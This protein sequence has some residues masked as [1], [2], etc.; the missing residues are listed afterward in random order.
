MATE[1]WGTHASAPPTTLDLQMLT[2]YAKLLMVSGN[3]NSGLHACVVG[4]LRTQW[5]FLLWYD[6]VAEFEAL[7]VY[8]RGKLSILVLAFLFFLDRKAIRTFQ[9]YQKHRGNPKM[10]NSLTFLHH[11]CIWPSQKD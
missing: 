11:P 1:L 2:D 4:A 10:M 7:P 5:S 9:G 3:L 8:S 6:T